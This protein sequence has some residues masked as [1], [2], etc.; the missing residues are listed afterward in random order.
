MCR[1]E[2][3]CHLHLG[4]PNLHTGFPE[5]RQQHPFPEVVFLFGMSHM[6]PVFHHAL[7]KVGARTSVRLYLVNPCE[8]PWDEDPLLRPVLNLAGGEPPE[9]DDPFSLHQDR[10]E[11]ILQRW[12]RP[13]REQLRLL[14]GLAQGDFLGQ[15]KVPEEPTLLAY[16]Q[17]RILKPERLPDPVA[18]ERNSLRVVPCPSPRREAEIVANL[19]WERLQTSPDDLH[20]G[21]IGVLVPSSEQDAYEEHLGAAFR[22]AHDIPWAKAMGASRA[23]Q[24]L[25][26]ASLLLLGL[27]GG[28]LTRA[29]LLRA[30]SH[31]FIQARLGATPEN[32]GLLCDQAGIVARLDTAETAGTYLEGGRWTWEEGLMIPPEPHTEG[33]RMGRAIGTPGPSRTDKNTTF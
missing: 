20:F 23:L 21:D 27:V 10:S 15:F 29:D 2:P 28:D 31:P 32:W 5:V 16:L 26:E 3:I 22:S 12:A 33:N 25:V 30:A 9:G 1:P 17:Q 6:A 18:D 13:A 14:A 4:H 19:I 8:E 7:A 24:E 11:V